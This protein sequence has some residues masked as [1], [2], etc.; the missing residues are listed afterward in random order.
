MEAGLDTNRLILTRAL[1][2]AH[3]TGEAVPIARR[4]RDEPL[5]RQSVY[6]SPLEPNNW[7][8]DLC[9][10]VP[11]YSTDDG[12]AWRLLGILRLAGLRLVLHAPAGVALVRVELWQE[13][14]TIGPLGLA[15][16]QAVMFW[17]EAPTMA[18]AACCA[19][20]AWAEAARARRA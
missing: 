14:T 2:Y 6:Q 5:E 13:A 3:L 17:G 19:A 7:Y 15:S 9:S 10:N 16:H 4:H 1:G 8:C 12:D 11:D 20:L 18:L